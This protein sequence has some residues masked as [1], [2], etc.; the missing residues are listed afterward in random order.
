MSVGESRDRVRGVLVG[1]AAGDRNGGPI[2]MAVMLAKSLI[3]RQRFDPEDLLARYLGWWREGSF[4]TGPTTAGVLGLVAGGVPN[5]EAVERVHRESDG[6]T[7]GCNPAHRCPPLAMAASLPDE[8]LAACALQ[9][10][11]LT[12]FDPLAG[13]VAAAVV[14]LCRGLI[15]GL[16][17][18]AALDRAKRGR[19][20]ATI[21]ALGMESRDPLSPGGFAPEV[22]RAA[23]HF[24]TGAGT[25]EGSL[26]ESLAFA[27]SANYSPVLAGAIGGARWGASSIPAEML[28]HCE[29]LP[30]VIQAVEALAQGW[31]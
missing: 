11:R 8:G 18:E 5:T 29:V 2:R 31:K 14:T 3:E 26:A 13:D 25:F 9:E 20:Q 21:W 7:A 1:L 12:H 17:W 4:D 30:R 27:G 19:S 22:L 10:A 15:R 23:V 24:V 6:L 16:P 28:A